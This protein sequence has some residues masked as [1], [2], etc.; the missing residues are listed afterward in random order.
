VSGAISLAEKIR[1]SVAGSEYGVVGPDGPA[2]IT[3]SI[4]VAEF[5]QSTGHTFNRADR[6]LYE[7]KAAGKDCVVAASVSG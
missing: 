4:G 6:A 2:R 1:G 5:A 7:A 3:V